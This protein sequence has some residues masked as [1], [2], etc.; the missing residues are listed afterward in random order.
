MRSKPG[1]AALISARFGNLV[2][3]ILDYVYV[4]SI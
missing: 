1:K 4:T 3:T 2:V